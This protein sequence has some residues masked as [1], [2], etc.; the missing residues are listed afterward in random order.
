MSRKV[1]GRGLDALI[2]HDA[3]SAGN[4][5]EEV[6]HMIPTGQIQPNPHQPRRQ[7]DPT[8]LEELA[9]SI[10]ENGILEP[11]IVRELDGGGF[12]LVAGERRLRAAQLAGRDEVTAL[13]RGFEARRSLEVATIANL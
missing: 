3:S 1:L 7:F 4:K 9:R 13:L 10:G 8:K 12:E 5:R 2:S 6:V 11:L